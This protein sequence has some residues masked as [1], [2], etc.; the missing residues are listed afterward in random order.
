[1]ISTYVALV[2]ITFITSAT[3]INQKLLG[4]SFS[5]AGLLTPYHLGASFAL[6][7]LGLISQSTS[8]S[9]A[10]GGALAAVTTA[11]NIGHIEGLDGCEY[12]AER[13]RAEGTRYTLKVALNKV[14]ED[15]IPVDSHTSLNNR[16]AKCSLA[17]TE[18][19]PKQYGH[20]IDS[21]TSK[22]DLIEVL[23]ASC[24][25]PF[26]FN[27]NWPCVK[28]RGTAGVDGFFAIPRNR[29]GCPATYSKKELIICPFLPSSV[30]LS[31]DKMGPV[32]NLN[33]LDD[34]TDDNLSAPSDIIEMPLPATKSY[35]LITPA[36]LKPSD[37]P[38]T[39]SELMSLALGPPDI[40]FPT[41]DLN[42]AGDMSGRENALASSIEGL[43]LYPEASS[44]EGSLLQLDSYTERKKNQRQGL[45]SSKEAYKLL[46]EA[47]VECV[48]I[49][50]ST[51]NVKEYK[52]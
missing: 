25:I 16:D 52:Q 14:L 47:G 6:K 34:S 26:Y 33:T 2:F 18:V 41:L 21:F 49:W 24:N 37:W 40:M 46:F 17:Y 22:E 29:F 27:G 45:M 31:A 35:E 3:A 51:V 39:I 10:S 9:G 11:L 36:L 1:M 32:I 4:V 50:A 8:V 7:R 5:P 43:A 28:V 38:F 12:I 44:L 15:L 20:I 19:Y 30:G 42:L 13:C 23:R 48:E